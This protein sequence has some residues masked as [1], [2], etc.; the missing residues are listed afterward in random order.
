MAVTPIIVYATD[1][2]GN[3]Q[4]GAKLYSYAA[5]TTTPQAIYTDSGLGTPSANPAVCDSSGRAVVWMDSSL[6]DYKLI[7]TNSAGSATYFS[8]DNIDAST[9]TPML[10][11]YPALLGDQNLNTTD[12]PTFASVTLGVVPFSGVVTD[13]GADRL[14]FW[15]DSDTQVEWLTLDTG[16]S[17]AANTLSLDAQLVDI[18]GLTPTDG[19]II[20]GDGT[21]FVT[22]SGATARTSLGLGAG[23]SPDFAGI[24][25][26]G[27]TT[28]TAILDEDAMG[29]DSATSLASQQSIKAYVDGKAVT[30]ADINAITQADGTI[31]VSDGTGWVGESGAAARTSLGLAIGTNV[32]AW[33]AQLDD[34]AALAPTDS[35]LLVGNGTNWVLESGATLRTSL[36]L[37]IGT[38]VQAHDAELAAL[39]G[40]TSAA[41]KIPYFTGSGTAAVSDFTAFAR[42]L[43][44]DAT[45]LAAKATLGF[46]II[47]PEDYAAI[48]DDSGE[49]ANNTAK[50]QSFF[51]ASTTDKIARIPKG[52]T[53][54]FDSSLIPLDDTHVEFYGDLYYTGA[55][56]AINGSTGGDRVKLLG[57]GGKLLSNA[58]KSISAIT[59]ANPGVVTSTAH[60]YS[61]SDEIVIWDADMV[62]LNGQIL[63]ITVSDANTYSIGVDTSAYTAYTTGG[64]SLGYVSAHR[65][66]YAQRPSFKA[67]TGATQANPVVITATSHNFSNGDTVYISDA[68]GMTEINNISFT[69]ANVTTNTYEL[70]GIDGTGYTSYTSGGYGT[71]F[72]YSDDWDISGLHIE[73]FMGDGV[74]IGWSR[75]LRHG[76][77]ITKYCGYS[78]LQLLSAVDFT[79]DRMIESGKMGPGTGG[80]AYPV[81][82]TRSYNSPDMDTTVA[83][84]STGTRSGMYCYDN[85][86]YVAYDTHGGQHIS[87][88]FIRWKNC[89][90]GINFEHAT[91][92]TSVVAPEYITFTGFEGEGPDPTYFSIGPAFVLDGRSAGDTEIQVGLSVGDGSVRRHGHKTLVSN[93]FSDGGVFYLRGS[94]GFRVGNVRCID[95]Y[96][97]GVYTNARV[98]GLDVSGL[99]VI[100]LVADGGVQAAV[101]I[102]DDDCTAVIDGVTMDGT[103]GNLL[104]LDGAGAFSAT[105]G[106][107]FGLNNQVRNGATMM[108]A[109]TK[110][111]LRRGAYVMLPRARLMLDGTTGI[112]AQSVTGATQANPVVITTSGTHGYANG[113]EVRLESLGGM[114][115]VNNLAFTIA[116]VTATTFELSGVDGTGYT[117]YTSGGTAFF[118]LQPVWET[119]ATFELSYD[120]ISY[121]AAG[122]YRIHVTSGI[123]GNLRAFAY[124]GTELNAS[125]V[126]TDSI[127]SSLIQIRVN[128]S[129]NSA[130]NDSEIWVEF[131][132]V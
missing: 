66:V 122:Q 61:T 118:C 68:G 59:Q 63:T 109:T 101:N 11:I 53:Y 128:D 31:I 47:T 77:L 30:V 120:H 84:P 117:A 111:Y 96:K 10:L 56:A 16:L 76:G 113:S 19:N 91:S 94:S 73:G 18:A 6:G 27:G 108:T 72:A 14:M 71:K 50:L 26:G 87:N 107:S 28:Y 4:S 104:R 39:A 112:A 132:G 123:L 17:I 8:Q 89:R 58:K 99:T 34:I 110:T 80:T 20:V 43:V 78:G 100:D 24:S 69:I 13:P 65:G 126:T 119:T 40:L 5:G 52:K 54:Y 83:P 74:R 35:N 22:E 130:V 44:D 114:T 1:L 21:N 57:F 60:G 129:S 41:D 105:K 48:A 46:D 25:L 62:E 124:G 88:G 38:D 127:S 2:N 23:N 97:S 115:E 9:I 55:G 116:N 90:H 82:D 125:S 42:T 70:S 36:G 121:R 67:I 12:S 81:T 75:R 45:A 102:A 103:A 86:N 33:D 98:H 7:L 93:T 49:A 79:A 131:G 95:C 106:V 51:D 29:S 37:A 3:V 64:V 85:P 15:D 92:D 32:Q